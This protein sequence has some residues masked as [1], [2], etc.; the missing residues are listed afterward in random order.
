MVR[1]LIWLIT[2]LSS[3]AVG[4]EMQCNRWG[5]METHATT[6]IHTLGG[7]N[8]SDLSLSGQW[9]SRSLKSTTEYY[10]LGVQLHQPSVVLDHVKIDTHIYSTPFAVK[11]RRTSG[12]IL[13]YHFAA[14]LE[15]ND[16][17]KLMAIYQSLHIESLKYLDLSQSK[18]MKEQDNTGTY[19]VRYSKVASNSPAARSINIHR[20]KLEYLSIDPAGG[21]LG[22]QLP[23]VKEDSYQLKLDSCGLMSIQGRNKTQVVSKSNDIRVSVIQTLSFN[24]RTAPVPE[25]MTIMLLGM[26]P[27]QWEV[28]PKHIVYPKPLPKPVQNVKQFTQFLIKQDLSG[29]E[30][31]KVAQLLYDNQRYL[32]ELKEWMKNQP[33]ED[34]AMSRLFMLIGKN[35]TQFAHQ[36]LVAVYRDSD[37]SGKQRFRSLMALKYAMTPLDDE[38]VDLLLHSDQSNLQVVSKESIRLAGSARLVLGII[39]QNQ[40]GTKFAERLTLK[41]A[42][43]LEL[44]SDPV[45][46][47][48]LLGAMGNTQDDQHVALVANYLNSQD[49]RVR[50]QAAEALGR[51]PSEEGL[52]L[53]RSQLS[54]ETKSRNIATVLRSIGKHELMQTE[55]KALFYY[56]QSDQKSD[57]RFAA[58][59]A[60]GRQVEQHPDLKLVLKDLVKKET[61]QK[62]L[63][64]LMKAIYSQ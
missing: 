53:L 27:L 41:L 25:D 52:K 8:D 1:Q 5:D 13:D 29:K 11:I 34:K 26:D 15:A 2:A 57:I 49:S 42:E 59:E 14:Q 46:Q 21:M 32:P 51:M 58:I 62:V 50:S 48:Y 54:V 56:A 4:A 39:I 35:D 36:L 24:H 30:D 9:V 37:F 6:E 45:R 60:I 47:S 16:R 17:Q 31:E 19:S 3:S 7:V 23:N 61:N 44:E 12:D 64:V 38:L 10:W 63:T 55:A 40:A 33:I 20:S 43:E 18:I 22:F 28:T